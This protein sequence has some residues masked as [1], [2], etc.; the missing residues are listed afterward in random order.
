MLA[1]FGTLPLF[2][3]AQAIWT[4]GEMITSPIAQA[5]TADIAPSTMRGRYLGC[6]LG[7]GADPGRVGGG[8]VGWAGHLVRGHRDQFPGHGWVPGVYTEDEKRSR[9]QSG[10][11]GR[12]R[13]INRACASIDRGRCAGVNERPGPRGPGFVIKNALFGCLAILVVR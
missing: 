4:T 3:L 2:F 8:P 9:S 10:G 11:A 7:R 1:F 5:F 12:A 13:R 6:L